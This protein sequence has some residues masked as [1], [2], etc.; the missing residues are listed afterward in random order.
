MSYY[1][2]DIQNKEAGGEMSQFFDKYFEQVEALLRIIATASLRDWE[3]CIAVIEKNK[4]LTFPWT[5]DL[6]K[7]DGGPQER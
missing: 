6:C 2:E 4:V 3:C 5:D 1:S 7:T